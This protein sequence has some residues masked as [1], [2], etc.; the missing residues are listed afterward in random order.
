[1]IVTLLGLIC[2]LPVGPM[3]SL[4]ARVLTPQTRSFGMGIFYAAYYGTM[5]L[6]PVIAGA[7]ANWSG[8]ADAAFDF[9]AVTLLAC[10]ALLWGFQRLPQVTPKIA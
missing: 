8:S 5:M 10:P 3:M 9:G 6:G 4:P 7:W 1:L 2:G